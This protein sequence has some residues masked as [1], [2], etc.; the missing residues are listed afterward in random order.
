MRRFLAG[1]LLC[2]LVVGLS[3]AQDEAET[4]KKRKEAIEKG[5]AWLKKGQGADWSWDYANGPFNIGVH[6]KQGTTAF[7]ALAL[8]KSGVAPDDP[9]VNKAF[10]FIHGCNLEHIYSAATVL[11]ALEARYNWEPPREDESVEEEKTA[12][13]KGGPKK[14]KPSGRDIDLAKRC[15]E[16]LVGNQAEDGTWSYP[17]PL[18][19]AKTDVSNT[20]YALLGFDAAERL[21]ISVPKGVYE[22]VLEFFLVNQEKDGPEVAAFPVP[23]ADMSYKELKKVEKDMRDKLKGAKGADER[24]AIEE[25]AARKILGTTE[26]KGA[27]KAR[28]WAYSYPFTRE[29]TGEQKGGR[30]AARAAWMTRVT[31]AMTTAGLASLFIC[32]AHLDGTKTLDKAKPRVDAALRDGAAW[33]AKNFSVTTNPGPSG[34][35][36]MHVLYYLYGLERAGVLLLAPKFG[37]HDW[38][39]E[40]TAYLLKKQAS[41]GSWDAGNEGTVGPVCDTCFALLFLSRGTTP[42][43]RIPTRTATGPGGAK[44]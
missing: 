6:M 24:R 18:D 40:G 25:D 33:M 26:K 16:F 29:G 23:G 19:E 2:V 30:G 36:S 9:A 32:K 13:K 31:G 8:L 17:K 3:R 27:M 4:S 20:Q 10:D 12:E 22:R 21:G 38:F 35:R 43:V 34:E 1:T 7:C 41:D 15:V 28:A 14:L 39:E 5:V 11:L 44:K 37:E 42:M